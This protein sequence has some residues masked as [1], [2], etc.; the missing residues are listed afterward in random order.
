MNLRG[1]PN[2]KHRGTLQGTFLGRLRKLEAE[3]VKPLT[4]LEG[5]LG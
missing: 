4:E 3:I 5:M 2:T 1:S